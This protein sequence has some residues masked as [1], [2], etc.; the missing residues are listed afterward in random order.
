M[1]R[2][3]PNMAWNQ[4]LTVNAVPLALAVPAAAAGIAYLNARTQFFYDYQVF[5][6]VIKGQILC[7]KR[8]TQDKLNMFYVL[9]GHALGKQGNDVFLIF[10]GRQWTYKE[11]YEIALK[12]GTW[13]KTKHNIQSKEVV[14]MDFMN[15]EK[16]VFLWFGLWSIGAKPAFIN[17]NLAG[18]ALSHCITVSTTRLVLIDVEIQ[19]NITQEIRDEVSN[20]QFEILTSDLELEVMATVGVREPDSSRTEKAAHGMAALIY[21]SGTTGL[22][23]PAVVS[24]SKINV[25]SKLIPSWM[26]YTTSDVFYT[27]R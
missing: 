10:E 17:Y 4:Q 6:S 22:P 26:S 8:E 2:E 23:K 1:L 24:W 18:K 5:G 21:T 14:A 27:V 19:E 15:S 7:A 11:T 3:T 9:E 12:Y 16:F 25:A 20:V 13:L